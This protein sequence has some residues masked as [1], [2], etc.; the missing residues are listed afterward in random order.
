MDGQYKTARWMVGDLTL[1]LL[2]RGWNHLPVKSLLRIGPRGRPD[3]MSSADG[4]L[5]YFMIS[6]VDCGY[7]M[8]LTGI[9]A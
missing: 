2:Q 8:M 1:E 9:V 4:Q 5:K 3:R 7:V 6:L